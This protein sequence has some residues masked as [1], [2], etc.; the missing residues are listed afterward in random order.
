MNDAVERI[1]SCFEGLTPE[2]VAL[3]G[4][5]Y[6]AD[7]RFSDPFNQVQGLEEIQRVLRRTACTKRCP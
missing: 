5:I 2:R 4:T 1:V 6:A 7:A 3:L